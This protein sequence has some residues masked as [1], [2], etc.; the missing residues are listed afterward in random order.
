MYVFK[1]VDNI[2]LAKN[3]KFLHYLQSFV[4]INRWDN[5][6][7][8]FYGTRLKTALSISPETKLS[9]FRQDELIFSK[10]L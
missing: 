7:V 3:N 2:K 8:L 1:S 10:V 5:L 4:L 9:L 6:R